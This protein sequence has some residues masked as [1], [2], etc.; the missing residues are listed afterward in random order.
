MAKAQY[1]GVSGVARKVKKNY[2]GVSAV[3]RKVK[4]GYI[5]VGGVARQYFA[6]ETPI[7]SL[8]VGGTVQVS[9]GGTLA[10]YIIVQIGAPN[11]NYVNADGYWLLRKTLWNYN[12]SNYYVKDDDND[13]LQDY[14]FNWPTV[15]NSNVTN[16]VRPAEVALYNRLPAKLQSLILEPTLM[17]YT[18]SSGS[19][20]YVKHTTAQPSKV[21]HLGFGEVNA[22]RSAVYKDEAVLQYFAGVSSNGQYGKADSLRVAYTDGGAA[23]SWWVRD[24]YGGTYKPGAVASDGNCTYWYGNYY[25]PCF[26][27][28]KTAKLE[29]L[30]S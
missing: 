17:N 10:D 15:T 21:F 1:I 27:V 29:D 24:G 19:R 18:Y 23:Q 2:I 25:R 22:W 12:N 30:L 4:K 13:P 20:E 3:A 26:I 28:P 5:G 16:Y 6:G 7:S 9:E 8:A 14:N 11:S